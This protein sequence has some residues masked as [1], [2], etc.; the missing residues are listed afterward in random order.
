MSEVAGK[1]RPKILH[2]AIE[3]SSLTKAQKSVLRVI[4]RLQSD[5][6]SYG[7]KTLAD[8]SGV[9][10]RTVRSAVRELE[11]AGILS[12]ERKEL[13]GSVPRMYRIDR[14]AI[15]RMNHAG[16]DRAIPEKEGGKISGVQPLAEIFRTEFPRITTSTVSSDR[17]A[18]KQPRPKES[19][20]NVI[21]FPAHRRGAKAEALQ[22]AVNSLAA[23]C[24]S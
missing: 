13:Y 9:T 10:P 17:D 8:R 18:A 3:R 15:L 16:T 22:G 5:E 12:L 21:P 1:I 4:V 23:G 20:S 11:K 2:S 6:M 14:A 7:L 19:R 24:M